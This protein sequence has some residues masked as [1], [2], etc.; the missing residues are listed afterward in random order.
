MDHYVARMLAGEIDHHTARV[1]IWAR[2]WQAGRM[3]PKRYGD[4]IDAHL[5][6]DI[7][8]HVDKVEQ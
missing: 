5:A 8:V 2:Q 4:K 7:V 3:N 6:G 1:A